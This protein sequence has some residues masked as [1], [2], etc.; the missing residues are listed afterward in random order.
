MLMV[1]KIEK[2]PQ[3]STIAVTKY[4]NGAPDNEESGMKEANS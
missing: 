4:R 1:I 2:E 3:Y